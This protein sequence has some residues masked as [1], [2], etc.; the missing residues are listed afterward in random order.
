MLNAGSF[1]HSEKTPKGTQELMAKVIEQKNHE[2]D[3]SCHQKLSVISD[4]F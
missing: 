4:K 3:G 2:E 1:S